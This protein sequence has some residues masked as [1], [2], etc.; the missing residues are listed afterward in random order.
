VS[1]RSPYLQHTRTDPER[2][3]YPPGTIVE[4]SDTLGAVDHSLDAFNRA[5]EPKKLVFFHGGHFDAYVRDQEV[6]AA[7][8]RDWYLQHLSA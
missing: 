1:T 4:D 3:Q 7:A 2:P 8:A 5:H 6:T